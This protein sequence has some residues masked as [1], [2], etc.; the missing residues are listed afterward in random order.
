MKS[1][2]IPLD[3]PVCIDGRMLV[4]GHTGVATYAR[5]LQ[6]AST[7]LSRLPLVVKAVS[8]PFLP[9]W[10]AAVTSGTQSVRLV[11][12]PA[13]GS[14]L[15]GDDLYRRAH[16][17]FSYRRQLY[18]LQSRDY[19]F[20]LMHWTYP[21][22]I[23][24]TGWINLYTVHDMIPID[25]PGL[26]PINAARHRAVLDAIKTEA[27]AIVTV[28][29]AA[30][31][32]II[33]GLCCEPQFVIDA[34]QAIDLPEPG[35]QPVRPP[36][37]GAL[38]QGLLPGGYLLILGSVEPR[39]NITAMI[40]AYRASNVMLPLVIAGPDGWRAAEVNALIDHTP[41][42]IRVPYLDR[43][44]AMRLV[45]NARALLFA[46]L[47]EGFGLPMVEAM[48][49]GVP[50]MTSD[51][52]ALAE[53]ADGAA[54]LVDPGDEHAMA[55][56]ISRIASDDVLCDT[57]KQLGLARAPAF[58]LSR[59]ADRLGAIYAGIV[60]ADPGS[61]DTRGHGGSRA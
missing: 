28:S 40:H 25:H 48:A 39:K 57:L 47:A 9:P 21:V 60:H 31:Q 44:D 27:N 5:M 20:G 61:P 11:G 16:I 38:P 12:D 4:N 35:S 7:R 13:G 14:R 50:V 46:S 51:R 45:A 49:M 10:L 8:A 52:G 59:F 23:H 29:Q 33:A 19:P 22:P 43:G 15:E 34:G 18:R 17:H 37:P 30:R 6:A 58:S 24:M 36:P 1:A 54:L 2:Q 3:I 32:S 26:T 42:V 56:A 55:V 41:R 53:V